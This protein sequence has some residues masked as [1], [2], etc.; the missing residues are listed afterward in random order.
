MRRFY[1]RYRHFAAR[2]IIAMALAFAAGGWLVYSPYLILLLPVALL[3]GRG[4]LVLVCCLFALGMARTLPTA[5][6]ASLFPDG[7]RA[8]SGRVATMP[9]MG[10]GHQRFILRTERGGVLVYASDKRML[11]PG[12]SVRATGWVSELRGEQTEF[13]RRRGIR[14]RIHASY[15]G[16][17]VE[18]LHQGP[19]LSLAAAQWRQSVWK[20]LRAHLPYEP[21]SVAMAILFGQD[22][23]LPERTAENMRQAGTYHL[24]AT[25]G[26]NV[27]ILVAGLMLLLCHLPVP[28][29]AQI[30]LALALLGIYA[31]AVGMN[32]PIVRAISMA[33][34]YLSAM[35]FFRIPDALSAWGAAAL[36]YLSVH[37]FAVLDAGF[38][39]SFGVVLALILYL[40]PALRAVTSWSERR[41]RRAAVRMAVVALSAPVL[42]TVVA[43]VAALPILSHHFGELSLIAPIANL[44]TGAAVPFVYIG[45]AAS[46]LFRP[47]SEPLSSGFDLLITGAFSQW[48]ASVNAFFAD[49]PY[50][51]VRFPPLPAWAGALG[52]LWVPL[53]SRHR[54][55]PVPTPEEAAGERLDEGF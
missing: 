37:P 48:I 3:L 36:A 55:Y 18:V 29:W 53:F 22:R 45:N 26:F 19:P 28:R 2:P 46:L 51:S 54:L 40:P 14:Q 52:F 13:W 21:A 32:P 4:R 1:G 42:T 33:A 39:L 11:A 10:V 49:L 30:G 12:D 9:E 34:I 31:F 20:T 41:F 16:S 25:S 23:L 24:V 44:F 17:G 43:Q 38:Q 15:P 8:V 35:F 27:L 6:G 5:G 47:L 50:S 7:M